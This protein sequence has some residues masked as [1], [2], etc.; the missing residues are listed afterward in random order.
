MKR[1]KLGIAILGLCT[2][3]SIVFA[4]DGTINFEGKLVKS[5]CVP[6]VTDPNNPIPTVSLPILSIGELNAPAKTA[7]A[8]RFT[9]QLQDADGGTCTAT[10]A[11]GLSGQ[12]Y[13]EPESE[14]VNENGRLINT[15]DAATNVDIQLLNN[16]K[17]P[18]NLSTTSNEQIASENVG[19]TF[20]YYAQYYATAAAD[21]GDVKASVSY[22]I[23]YK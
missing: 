2:S 7:G 1:L 11:G 15:G 20:T 18:I 12:P 9:I 17:E 22:T 21:A 16:N 8:E 3:S 4:A 14:K 10:E 5:T 13:F 23:V 6:V 19:N